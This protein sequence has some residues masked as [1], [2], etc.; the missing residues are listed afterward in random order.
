MLYS[1]TKQQ[2]LK[3]DTLFGD[4]AMSYLLKDGTRP[5][6]I[7]VSNL[8]IA[9]HTNL[10]NPVSVCIAK[11]CADIYL[12]CSSVFPSLDGV[13]DGLNMDKLYKTA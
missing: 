8:A 9:I 4:T 7:R 3:V 13:I 5:A 11:N 6:T 12:N 2:S 1:E 10:K